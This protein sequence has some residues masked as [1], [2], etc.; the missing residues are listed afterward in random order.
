MRCV[1]HSTPTYKLKYTIL[2]VTLLVVWGVNTNI[3]SMLL[4]NE[5]FPINILRNAV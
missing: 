2:K 3:K 1:A 4:L 5:K